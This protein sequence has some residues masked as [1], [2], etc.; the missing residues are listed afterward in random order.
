MFRIVA[1]I[2]GL[3]VIIGVIVMNLANKTD[4]NLFGI[5]YTGLPVYVVALVSFALGGLYA[6]AYCLGDWIRAH[7][8]RKAKAKEKLK[9]SSPP[10][11]EPAEKG[12][13]V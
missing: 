8:K 9:N 10:A 13:T 11:A 7:G 2:A 3:I 6:F 1:V 4:F 12:K 5:V